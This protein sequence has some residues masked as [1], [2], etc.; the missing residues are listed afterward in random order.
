L[1][2]TFRIDCRGAVPSHLL[3]GRL[4]AA[5]GFVPLAGAAAGEHEPLVAVGT[6]VVQGRPETD[7]TVIAIPG[8]AGRK[9]LGVLRFRVPAGER[10]ALGAFAPGTR[11]RLAGGPPEG[12]VPAIVPGEETALR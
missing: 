9:T 8:V 4:D 11:F 5:G 2:S 3:F 7:V 10:L 6:V 1:D 12:V